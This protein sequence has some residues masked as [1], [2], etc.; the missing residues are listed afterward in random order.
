MK[1][2]NITLPQ[3]AVAIAEGFVGFTL[4]VIAVVALTSDVKALGWD[5]QDCARG[6]WSQCQTTTFIETGVSCDESAAYWAARNDI[7]DGCDALIGEVPFGYLKIHHGRLNTR[8]CPDIGNH[9]GTR[10]TIKLRAT[11]YHIR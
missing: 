7:D 11:C 6:V 3:L 4:V 9:I 8:S 2:R 5:D 1:L 10:H